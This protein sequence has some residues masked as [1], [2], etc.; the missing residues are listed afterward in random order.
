MGVSA[1]PPPL[2]NTVLAVAALA[3][4]AGA[5]DVVCGKSTT[6]PINDLAYKVRPGESYTLQTRKIT[7]RCVVTYE[8]AGGCTSLRLKCTKFAVPNMDQ[9]QCRQGDFLRVRGEPESRLPEVYCYKNK[10]TLQ[11]PAVATT[12][13]K[14][15]YQAGPPPSMPR[16]TSISGRKVWC[17]RCTV[18]C[19]EPAHQAV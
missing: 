5:D 14:I 13:M 6:V 12:R 2:L 11:Y 10:P 19:P 16:T 4:T 15:T 1:M 3:A 8:A 7:R 9:D 18:P 17:V